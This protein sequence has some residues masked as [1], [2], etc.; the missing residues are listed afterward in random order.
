VYDTFNAIDMKNREVF[1]RRRGL[2]LSL[3]IDKKFTPGEIPT[4][5][6]PL[7]AAY[8]TISAKTLARD[9]D[10]LVTHK[11]IIKE[12]GLYFANIQAL[13]RM[14]AKRKGLILH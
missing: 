1:K 10:E 4:L 2:A 12:D 5:S 9:I 7:A 8:S 11:I 3:P 14:I 13:N 6:I